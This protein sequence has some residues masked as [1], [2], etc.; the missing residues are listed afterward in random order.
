MNSCGNTSYIEFPADPLVFL[1]LTIIQCSVSPHIFLLI[2]IHNDSFK[3]KE[4]QIFAKI[5][6][7]TGQTQYRIDE[8]NVFLNDSDV[9]LLTAHAIR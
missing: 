7:S 9:N 5:T 3:N 6:S 2:N 1:L 4:T 8:P